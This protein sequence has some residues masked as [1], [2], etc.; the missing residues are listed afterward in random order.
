MSV[1]TPPPITP[2]PT[3]Y[4]QRGDRG[5]FSDRLDGFV[6]WLTGACAEFA[7]LAA[8]AYNNAVDAYNSAFAAAAS[9]LGAAG[10]AQDA[11]NSA[12]TA[13]QIAGATKWISGT[14]YGDGVAVWSPT[15]YQ[16]YRKVGAGVSNTD[17]GVNITGWISLGAKVSGAGG[18]VVNGSV[19]LTPSSDAAIC[20]KPTKFGEFA[21]LPNATLLSEGVVQY[22]VY[23]DSPFDYGIKDFT[24]TWIGWIRPFT[25]SLINLIESTSPAGKWTGSGLHKLAVTSEFIPTNQSAQYGQ[26]VRRVSLDANREILFFQGGGDWAC[27]YDASTNSYGAM[28]QILSYLPNSVYF[29][30]TLASANLLLLV[31]NTGA[32]PIQVKAMTIS[33]SGFTITPNTGGTQTYTGTYSGQYQ[34]KTLTIGSTHITGWAEGG[35]EHYA[36][37]ISI[38]GTTPAFGTPRALASGGSN[39]PLFINQDGVLIAIINTSNKVECTPFSISGNSLAYGTIAYLSHATTNYTMRAYRNGVGNIFVQHDGGVAIFKIVGTVASVSNYNTGSPPTN[40]NYSAIVPISTNKMLVA[41]R[42]SSGGGVFVYLVTDNN[43]TATGTYNNFDF[44]GGSFNSITS[45]VSNGNIA[46]ILLGASYYL[47]PVDV[48]CSGTS[49]TLSKVVVHEFSASIG[50]AYPS[51]GQDEFGTVEPR[52][53]QTSTKDIWCGG[54]G[55]P[56]SLQVINGEVSYLYGNTG[57]PDVRG[58]TSAIRWGAQ[59]PFTNDGLTLRKIEVC[60]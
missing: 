46:K 24:G 22:S 40:M 2:V 5:T 11:A 23:N 10:Y 35:S 21:T 44:Y 13:A 18:T 52:Q 54:T 30:L 3:P 9:A 50:V 28:T 36:M 19:T 7:A 14:T 42:P 4:I 49:P 34:S 31:W 33:V 43:G 57:R 39:A 38:S 16:T 41:I 37:G 17:P 59:K 56:A 45:L 8:N 26:L 48:D 53:F 55:Y 27:V 60:E 51:Q 12:N 47:Y 58:R 6:R 25:G 1:V 32:N 15:D 29:D 20:A